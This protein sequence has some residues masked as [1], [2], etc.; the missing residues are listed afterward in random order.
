VA[1]IPGSNFGLIV[2]IARRRNDRRSGRGGGRLSGSATL[3]AEIA[4]AVSL[5]GL[6]CPS[7][8]RL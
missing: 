3:G 8:L 6:F 5:D 7:V 2:E 4:D 1:A